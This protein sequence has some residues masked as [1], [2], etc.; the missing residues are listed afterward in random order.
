[1]NQDERIEVVDQ[2]TTLI[3]DIEP[4]GGTDRERAAV[5]LLKVARLLLVEDLEKRGKD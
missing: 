2:L 1:M 4:R 3:D 5:E